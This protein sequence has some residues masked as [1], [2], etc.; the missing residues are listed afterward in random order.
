MQ[1]TLESNQIIRGRLIRYFAMGSIVLM[2]SRSVALAAISEDADVTPAGAEVGIVEE[3]GDIRLNC[4]FDVGRKANAAQSAGFLSIMLNEATVGM[5][6][7]DS[8]EAVVG[9]DVQ[10]I[11]GASNVVRQ[12]VSAQYLL[13]VVVSNAYQYSVNYYLLSDVVG[14]NTNGMYSGIGDPVKS[15]LIRNPDASNGTPSRIFVTCVQ[16]SSTD[17]FEC[18]YATPSQSSKEWSLI[19]GGGLS[20]QRWI[21]DLSVTAGQTNATVSRI[22]YDA[23]QIICSHSINRWEALSFGLALVKTIEDPDGAALTRVIDYYTD[24][25]QTGKVGQ[26]AL[27]VDYNG[28]WKRYDYDSQSRVTTLIEPWKDADTNSPLDACR[29][30]QYDYTPVD[31][32]DNGTLEPMTARTVVEAVG[33]A[34]VGKTY[35]AVFVKQDEEVRIQEICLSAE[36]PYGS[37]N[38]L[39]DRRVSF[40]VGATNANALL[41]RTKRIELKDGTVQSYTYERGTYT[42]GIQP[43]DA[44]FVAGSG[45]DVCMI[46]TVGTLSSPAGIPFKTTQ[47]HTVTDQMGNVVLAE[48]YVYNGSAYE[49]IKWTVSDYNEHNSLVAQFNSDNQWTVYNWSGRFVSSRKNEAGEQEIF[50]RDALQRV[51][52]RTV[53]GVAGKVPDRVQSF[54][55]DALGRVVEE[56]TAMGALV[57]VTSNRY[58]LAGRLVNASVD[59]RIVATRFDDN[60]RTI[61]SVRGDGVAATNL[62]YRDNRPKATLPGQD[63][64]DQ[65]FDYLVNASNMTQITETRYATANSPKWLRV[66]RDGVGRVVC[67]EQSWKAGVSLSERSFYN[68]R[69]LLVRVQTDGMG[70]P[71]L[72]EYDELGNKIR[73]G[74]DNDH[75]NALL[76]SSADQ[77]D[78]SDETMIKMDGDW[79]KS[80]VAYSWLSISNDIVTTNRITLQRLTGLASNVTS[81]MLSWDD[82]SN[83]TSMRTIVDGESKT[84]SEVFTGPDSVI[85]E[86]RV[87]ML[88]L[89][90]LRTTKTG[91]SISSIYAYDANGYTLEEADAASGETRKHYDKYGNVDWSEDA[92][93]NC[94]SYSCDLYSGKVLA[95]SDA[96]TNRVFYRYDSRSMRT[97]MW[98]SGVHPTKWSYNAYGQRISTSTFR[99]GTGWENSDWPTGSEGVADVTSNIYEEASGKLLATIGP[100][101]IDVVR[102][103]YSDL[104]Y[105]SGW[106]GGRLAGT[107]DLWI[108]NV[109]DA[110]TGYRIGIE[111]SDGTP[112]VQFTYDRAGRIRTVQDAVGVRTLSYSGFR[113]Q[114]ESITGMCTVTISHQYEDSVMPGRQTGVKV[115][116][117]YRARYSYD[118]CGRMSTVVV[119][120]TISGTKTFTYSYISNSTLIA[121]IDDDSGRLHVARA[122]DRAGALT[123]NQNI[124][125]STLVSQYDYTYD[126]RGLRSSVLQSGSVFASQTNALHLYSKNSRRELESV[127][128][129]IEGNGGGTNV[130]DISRFQ[131]FAYDNAGNRQT[132][133]QSTNPVVNY[134]VNALNQYASI[135]GT[136]NTFDADGNLTSDGQFSNMW[137]A[138]NRL[139]SVMPL[140]VVEGSRKVSFDY[141]YLGRRVRRVVSEYTNGEWAPGSTNVFVY[142]GWN[143]ICK[144]VSDNSGISTNLYFWGLDAKGTLGEAG[145]GVGGLLA[146]T[147]HSGGVTNS[148]GYA[149]DGAGNVCQLVDLS[150]SSVVAHYEYDGYGGVVMQSGAVA[151]KNCFRFSTKMWDVDAHA[152]Y[153]GMRFYSPTTGRWLNRDPLF[154][155]FGALGSIP[156]VASRSSINADYNGLKSVDVTARNYYM[157]AQNQPQDRYDAFG[158]W[159]VGYRPWQF[160]IPGKQIDIL[161]CKIKIPEIDVRNEFKGCGNCC[162]DCTCKQSLQGMI[163]A[164]ASFGFSCSFPISGAPPPLPRFTLDIAGYYDVGARLSINKGGCNPQCEL[165]GCFVRGWRAQGK[166]CYKVGAFPIGFEA[167]CGGEFGSNTRTC[168][169]PSGS[170]DCSWKR[171]FCE[172]C[173][174]M[175]WKKDAKFCKTF[176][177]WDSGNSGCGGIDI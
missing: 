29:V 72:Y 143:M 100:D 107:N 137:N 150:D 157:Y 153:Y 37:T 168:T 121:S 170:R 20:S 127:H 26:V 139:I 93:S 53:P 145:G 114:A 19:T 101:G 130:E 58:D 31:S 11:R 172:V 164:R 47:M 136:T 82:M 152:Y 62:V 68:L 94:T 6:K 16:G 23:N 174:D 97:H 71:H 28:S 113:A 171:L 123:R 177:I 8:L 34:V 169:C 75:D 13:D 155:G 30:T 10:L 112:N 131:N 57:S 54:A 147:W 95:T 49:R 65:Y 33:N 1:T 89:E 61:V 64:V 126:S 105:V 158:L 92:Y 35:S 161:L 70:A 109:F 115:D 59:G 52:T 17:A 122:Y 60:G 74:W 102:V 116:S 24:L 159:C 99:N 132:S 73:S 125:E 77:M 118:D 104:G 76:G 25:T 124:V 7:P 96:A 111:Y 36:S 98:G 103:R 138:E 21:R 134:S 149:Y 148:Y 135:W 156:D 167:C 5:S 119:S 46:V 108:T 18:V 160:K 27:I 120:P 154:N 14:P 69:G 176:I 140:S 39:R 110:N 162:P 4:R 22:V 9:S 144:I 90:V 63:G 117:A 133:S 81:E 3:S 166:I 141:D 15:I 78:G 50:Q 84:R 173:W 91:G 106:R 42:R 165:A 45:N 79:W 32:N 43:K 66:Y 163:Q 12:L 146:A 51:S 41:G 44:V 87:T 151:S 85:G 2:A 80:N 48:E 83:R 175:F 67:E 86:S 128:R 38:N 129:Y 55:Y 142:D 56:T 88:G 40:P